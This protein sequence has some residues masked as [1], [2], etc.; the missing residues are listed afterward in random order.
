MVTVYMLI[1]SKHGKA[2]LVWSGLR[3][4]EEITE[5]HEIYGRFDIIAKVEADDLEK[6]KEFVQNK[7]R[8]TEGIRKTEILM[9]SDSEIQEDPDDEA[10][11]PESDEAEEEEMSD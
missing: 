7:V 2:K 4:F 11:L 1:V 5:I 10:F 9:V 8:I 6:L 3:K